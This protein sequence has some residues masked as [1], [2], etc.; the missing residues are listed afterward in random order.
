MIKI[1][2]ETSERL[3]HMIE[4]SESEAIDAMIK[5]TDDGGTIRWVERLA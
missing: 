1:E 4:V 5:I 2:Y 3:P